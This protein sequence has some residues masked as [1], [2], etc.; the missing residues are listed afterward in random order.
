MSTRRSLDT[1]PGS[2]PEILPAG[3]SVRFLIDVTTVRDTPR[4]ILRCDPDGSVWASIE[5]ADRRDVIEP[6]PSVR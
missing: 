2:L 6:A 3:S 5:T 1:R 4:L